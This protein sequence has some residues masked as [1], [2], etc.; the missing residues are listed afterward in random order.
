MFGIEDKHKLEE[1]VT[2]IGGGTQTFIFSVQ[3]KNGEPL[4]IRDAEVKWTLSN[5]GQKDTP[6]LIK[7]NKKNGGVVVSTKVM[8]EFTVDITAEDTIYLE[9]SKY[10]QEPII[11]QPSGKVLRPAYGI[12]NIKKGVIY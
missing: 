6:I 2:F 10:E 5:I 9:S 8:G 3:D 4:D 1:D 7:D 11:I 12:V